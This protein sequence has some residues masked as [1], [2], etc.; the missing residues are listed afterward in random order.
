M[1]VFQGHRS[2]QEYDENGKNE[3]QV[4]FLFSMVRVQSLLI[5][6]RYPL[7]LRLLIG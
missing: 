4:V 2:N 7:D 6:T 5:R 3:V 1:V